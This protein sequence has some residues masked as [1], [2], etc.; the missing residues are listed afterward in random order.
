M[1]RL[2]NTT[3][4]NSIQC[5]SLATEAIEATAI[6]CL[7]IAPEA[8]AEGS[9]GWPG[10]SVAEPETECCCVGSPDYLPQLLQHLQQHLPRLLHHLQPVPAAT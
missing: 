9:A 4:A 3:R 1:A 8:W 6:R 2:G 7:T 5:K 10:Q